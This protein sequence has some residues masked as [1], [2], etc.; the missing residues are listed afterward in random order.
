MAKRGILTVQ[1][2]AQGQEVL[3]TARD[4]GEGTSTPVT[5]VYLDGLN[6]Q[7]F[8]Q[9]ENYIKF[10]K[11]MNGVTISNDGDYPLTAYVNGMKIAVKGGEVLTERFLPFQEIVI[12]TQSSFRVYGLGFGGTAGANTGFPLYNIPQNLGLTTS[13]TTGKIYRGSIIQVR[14]NR[15]LNAFGIIGSITGWQIWEVASDDKF[16]GTAPLASGTF[17][18]T[19]STTDFNMITLAT[20]LQLTAGKK[21]IVIGIYVAGP[22]LTN[23]KFKWRTDADFKAADNPLFVAGNSYQDDVVPAAGVA[24]ATTGYVYQAKYIFGGA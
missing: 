14:Q 5:D 12:E 9:D 2:N 8:Y 1:Q 7:E 21:Y 16:I 17:T 24:I 3:T 4:N 22:A 23:A 15:K 11:K 6:V 20:P 19:P 18:G 13:G 10:S